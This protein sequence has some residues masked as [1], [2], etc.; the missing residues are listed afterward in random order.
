MTWVTVTVSL[1][2]LVVALT[3]VSAIVLRDVLGVRDELLSMARHVI[4]VLCLLPGIVTFRNYFHGLAMLRR[5]TG[6]MGAGAVL[7]NLS[8][9][10][11]SAL[12][13]AAGWLN[14]VTASATLLL[15]FAAETA[16]VIL[17][18]KVARGPAPG[19]PAEEPDAEDSD[20]A[21]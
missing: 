13:L 17:G 15:G 9:Y 5:Q 2:M 1:F 19:G 3:P 12:L 4:V 10:G 7:R 8:I 18:P 16:V 14:H 6:P 21:A 20:T 11:A